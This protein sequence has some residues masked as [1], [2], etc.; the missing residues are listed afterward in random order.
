MLLV[1]D[2]SEGNA[3]FTD[4]FEHCQAQHRADRAVEKDPHERKPGQDQMHRLG[5]RLVFIVEGLPYV[6][7][8][9]LSEGEAGRHHRLTQFRP[10]NGEK[11]WIKR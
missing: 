10:S 8:K 5:D 3:P 7:V 1:N 4:V 2:R 6:T 11:G 9:R